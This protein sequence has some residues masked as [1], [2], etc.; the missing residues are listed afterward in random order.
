MRQTGTECQCLRGHSGAGLPW[1]GTPGNGLPDAKRRRGD[2]VLS[3]GIDLSI[4]LAVERR[5][6]GRSLRARPCRARLAEQLLLP[7]A[8]Q[9]SRDPRARAPR[10]PTLSPQGKVLHSLRKPWR[11][12]TTWC[13]RAGI[14][15][16]QNDRADS[17]ECAHR[18]SRSSRA[19]GHGVA[20]R[21]LSHLGLDSEPPPL[22]RAEPMIGRGRRE[23]GGRDTLPAGHGLL[24]SSLRRSPLARA[25]AASDRPRRRDR[26][27]GR[28]GGASP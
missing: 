5:P 28:G 26:P 17:T 16:A 10:A 24:A 11:D 8:S 19:R 18:F 6:V 7:K 15:L 9:L 21:I 12:G 3:S 22:A 14:I 20:R 25:T 23:G 1:W 2:G 13:A 27:R 4:A